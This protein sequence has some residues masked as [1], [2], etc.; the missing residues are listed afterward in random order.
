MSITLARQKALGHVAT[1]LAHYW[2]QQHADENFSVDET[3]IESK[4]NVWLQTVL[5]SLR[6]HDET[7]ELGKT[8]CGGIELGMMKAVLVKN[9]NYLLQQQRAHAVAT[10]E[11]LLAN[12]AAEQAAS[13][14]VLTYIAQEL[15]LMASAQFTHLR[16][17][18]EGIGHSAQ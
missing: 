5:G 3:G 6:A 13:A 16:E 2:Q 10:G 1:L 18:T 9:V 17:G 14:P 7:A 12:Y 8:L 15:V 11:N 4:I